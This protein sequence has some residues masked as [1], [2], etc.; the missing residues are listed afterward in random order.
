MML[1][2][3]FIKIRRGANMNKY[4]SVHS[5]LWFFVISVLFFSFFI[6]VR[7]DLVAQSSEKP[8]TL[9]QIIS[10]LKV[11]KEPELI[12]QIEKNKINFELSFE[13][14]AKLGRS[15]ASDELIL[16]IKNNKLV[17]KPEIRIEKFVRGSFI[18]GTVTG[19]TPVSDYNLYKIVV[20]VKTNVWFIHP[21]LESFA[22]ISSNGAWEIETVER[23]PSPSRIAVFLVNR[24]YRA[25][26][27]INRTSEI[28]AVAEA[29]VDYY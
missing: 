20:Y 27:T 9:E 21:F 17:G 25:P 16:T 23:Q 4:N 5:R 6:I 15:G 7:N 1:F 28:N 8:Y 2:Q 26:S 29:I 13:N 3:G 18:S 22:T 11:L 24:D 10:L 19:I 12:K 14:G